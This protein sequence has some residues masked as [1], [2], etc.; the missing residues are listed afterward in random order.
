MELTRS[1]QISHGKCSEPSDLY[2]I[3]FNQGQ[4]SREV[5]PHITLPLFR[6]TNCFGRIKSRESRYGID[7]FV[8]FW[9]ITNTFYINIKKLITEKY[10]DCFVVPSVA[11]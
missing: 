8:F 11:M 4:I 10:A 6:R 7:Y 3:C 1:G 5:L 2:N 9:R